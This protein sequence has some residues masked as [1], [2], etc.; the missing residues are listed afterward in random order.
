MSRGG[1]S[2]SIKNGCLNSEQH[3]IFQYGRRHFDCQNPTALHRYLNLEMLQVPLALYLYPSLTNWAV[4]HE[5]L[6]SS[7][8]SPRPH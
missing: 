7:L 3:G 6:L 1:T 5:A 8:A 4:K 2:W